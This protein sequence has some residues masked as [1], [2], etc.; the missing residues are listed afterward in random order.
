M[1][2][3]VSYLQNLK[4]E[5]SLSQ[6]RNHIKIKMNLKEVVLKHYLK[7]YAV[8]IPEFSKLS[9]THKTANSF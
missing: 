6:S 8:N 7:F 3:C 4:M 1:C 5:G 2:E 9:K